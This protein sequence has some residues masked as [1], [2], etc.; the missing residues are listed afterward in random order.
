MFGQLWGGFVSLAHH[1]VAMPFSSMTAAASGPETAENQERA[2]TLEGLVRILAG[3]GKIKFV[4]FYILKK[5]G[6]TEQNTPR[7]W[8]TVLGLEEIQYLPE[9]VDDPDENVSLGRA[10]HEVW[11]LLFSRPELIFDEPVLSKNMAFQALWWAVED[12]RVNRLGLKRHPGARPWIDAAYE[13]DYAVR[14]LAA[15]RARWT[16]ELPLHLQ[17]NYALIYEWWA[18]VTDP[19]ATDPKVL[20]ALNRARPAIRRAI[21]ASDAAASFAI[22]RD[23]IWP[24]YKELVDE[25][26]EREKQKQQAQQGQDGDGQQSE[27]D[28][29]SDSDSDSNSQS[30]SSSGKSKAQ[31]RREQKEKDA[32][33]AAKEKLEKAEKE[34]RD[35]HASKVVDSPEKMSQAEREKAKKDLEKMRQKM[36]Q[37]QDGSQAQPE[38]GQQGQDAQSGDSEGDGQDGQ[39][40]AEE[41]MKQRERLSRA[42]RD[43]LTDSDE[44]YETDHGSYAEYLARVQKH[45]PIMR[46]QFIQVLKR[47]IRRR[48]IRNRDSGDLDTDKLSKI[49][50]GERDLFKE[51]MIA[52]KTLYRVSLLIDISGSMS[53][54]K[55]ER[56][57]EGAVMMM[58][59]LEKVPGVQY[60]I[61]AFDDKPYVV[62]AY[63]E[64]ATA[65]VKEGVVRSL[66]KNGGSTQSGRAVLEAL[67]RIR[68]G[69]GDKLMIMVNDGDPDNNFDREEY[70]HMVEAQRDVDIQGVGLGPDAQ[71]VLDLFPPGRGWW[72]KDSAEF[73]KRLREILQKKMLH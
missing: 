73:A 18:G 58:E 72:L 23:E 61:V 53:G 62:K 57:I 6:E 42:E 1:V 14:N 33:K 15:E 71:L 21:A 9:D 13:R 22:V 52:N 7:R 48:V 45:V 63:N 28:E 66:L 44:D 37:K 67:E 31:K 8:R 2:H 47:K 43:K 64:R 27:S 25:A 51:S 50:G 65:K 34:F 38:Q 3:Y 56:A 4:P 17:F 20:D 29:E 32:A 35:K 49:P 26:Y 36:G 46:A 68:M 16:A 5:H 24:I 40:S 59:S 11:H 19:R 41:Q 60:E 10:S 70:R 12:P 55:K 69:R 54:E 30:G 39:K